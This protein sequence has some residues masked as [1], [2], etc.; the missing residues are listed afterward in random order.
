ML[1][2]T[3][4]ESYFYPQVIWDEN[5]LR[6]FPV[7]FS[8]EEGVWVVLITTGVTGFAGSFEPLEISIYF[9]WSIDLCQALPMKTYQALYYFLL[10]VD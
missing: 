8:I 9:S 2:F 5:Q 3:E 7:F 6:F 1:A 4:G 10:T